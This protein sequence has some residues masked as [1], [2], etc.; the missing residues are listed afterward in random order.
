MNP[1]TQSKNTTILLVLI[2]L[3]LACFALLPQ[4]RALCQ[5]ACL[6]NFNTVQGDDALFS[7]TSGFNNTALGFNALYSNTI[8]S[9]N[10]ANGVQALN[11]NT[12]GELNT[13]IGFQALYSN[14]TGNWNTA[15]GAFALQS[16]TT[17][18]A[19]TATGRDALWINTTGYW[20]TANGV[21]A[22]LYNTTGN[23]NTAIG[24]QA[25]SYNTGSNNV[26]LGHQAGFN[27]TTG[28]NNIHIGNPGAAAE[29]NGIRIGVKTTHRATYIAGISRATVPTGVAVIVDANGHLGTTTS[30]ARFKEAIKPMDK[31]SEGILALK[32]VTFHYKQE[33]DP[34]GIPQFGLVAE[35]VEKVNPDLVAR[36]D[37]G[38][39]YTV[40]YEAVNAMLLNEFLK[41]HRKVEAL[42][43]A[44]AEQ[45]KENA[46]M[47]A[48]L[49]E[50][51]AQ[52]QEINAH[53][54][55]SKSALQTIANNQ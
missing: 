18:Y 37:Q 26:A 42:D 30:S 25:L 40:R 51:A 54:E 55:M 5:D 49:K 19:N 29:S 20:N 9:W 52:I 41:E 6:T 28:S 15:N 45:Q 48:M 53:L 43:K 4:A 44:M 31:T 35:D 10:T 23:Y 47:R 46:A 14:T 36:D 16:N 2:P 33:I 7:L 17:G 21:Q 24:D 38:K 8:G 50:Q 32:P 11:S 22:L 12:T 13:A 27:L 39:P 1:L 3:L 34:E